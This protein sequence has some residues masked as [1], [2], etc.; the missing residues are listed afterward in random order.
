MGVDT[1]SVTGSKP[2]AGRKGSGEGRFSVELAPLGSYC[3][4]GASVPVPMLPPRADILDAKLLAETLAQLWLNGRATYRPLSRRK[5]NMRPA[6]RISGCASADGDIS[7]ALRSATKAAAASRSS[8]GQRRH[9]RGSCASRRRSCGALSV[10]ISWTLADGCVK[11]CRPPS[12]GDCHHDLGVPSI[13][14]LCLDLER[15]TERALRPANLRK[16]FDVLRY[17]AERAGRVVAKE[18]LIRAVWPDVTVGD[19][20]LTKC[21]SEVRQ[22]IG[23]EGQSVIKTIPRRGYLFD[24]PV[25]P[26]G[27][28]TGGTA[29]AASSVTPDRPS[30]AVLPFA[31]M[32]GDPQQEYISDGIVEDIITELSRFSGLFVIARNS[33]FQWKGGRSMRARLGV[34]LAFATC[35]RACGAPA[36]GCESRPSSSMRKRQSFVGG[37]LRSRRADVFALQDEVARTVAAILAAHMTRAE[38]E[39]TVLK[40]PK[41]WQAYD[42][43]ARGGSPRDVPSGHAGGGDV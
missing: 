26:T 43:H 16:S 24:V 8:S 13:R 30:V 3:P 38:A 5:G 23:D 10:E 7:R 12:A 14:V 21:I 36:S 17:L 1:A 35:W 41:S 34:N 9:V 22:A 11:F 25:A 27:I 29:G 6:R 28:P 39:R 15:L 42:H 2:C 19:E 18:E 32:S 33:S 40:P 37:A 20:S 31:N 4:A